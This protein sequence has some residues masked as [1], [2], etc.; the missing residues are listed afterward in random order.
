MKKIIT[1]LFLLISLI[2]L[3][4]TRPDFF[5]KSGCKGDII[6]IQFFSNPIVI[7]ISAVKIGGQPATIIS[8]KRVSTDDY[9]IQAQIGANA[10][11]GSVVVTGSFINNANASNV[12]IA[13]FITNCPFPSNNF[14]LELIDPTC[15]T[16]TNGSLK[17]T[18]TDSYYYTATMNGVVYNFKSNVLDIPNLAPSTYNICVKAPAFN[19]YTQCFE[20]IIKAAP[21][22]TGFTNTENIGNISFANINIE[23]GTAPYT[24]LLNGKTI[25]TTTD[26]TSRVVVQN[27]DLLEI[28]TSV[29][30]EGKLS[31]VISTPNELIVFPNPTSDF[32]NV[33][34]PHT[35]DKKSVTIQIIDSNGKIISDKEYKIIGSTVQIP[36]Q[37]LREGIYYINV[38]SEKLKTIKIMKK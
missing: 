15:Q 28:K 38:K 6:S 4:Q 35:S 30:C 24:I 32:I 18:A 9:Q 19:D 22:L 33:F 36:M 20:F 1:L 27:G 14:K 5:P 34:I 29:A 17:I 31:K 13:G 37:N 11:S 10:V 3:A 8:Q 7:S 25:S 26:K 2:A 16:K 12:S 21:G 23:T